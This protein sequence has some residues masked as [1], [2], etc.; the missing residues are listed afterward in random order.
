VSTEI[1]Q[2]S[3]GDAPVYREL[4][5]FGL[6]ESAPAFGS[7]HAEVAARPL[8]QFGERLADPQNHF[9]G[10]FSP[11]GDLIGTAILRRENRE[12][13]RHKASIFGMYVLPRYRGKGAARALLEA[14]LARAAELGV[15]Q[16][17]LGVNVEQQ[18]ALR[19]YESCGFQ[20]YG[21]ERDA[22]NVDGR[23]Y[24]VAYMVYRLPERS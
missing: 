8:D 19:L 6:Q 17:N 21:L 2:L 23:F 20:R 3:P 10:A 18:A 1:R 11:E 14:S 4:R 7:S 16:V 9:F 13:I 22:F 5:L 24:D 15:R 12:K